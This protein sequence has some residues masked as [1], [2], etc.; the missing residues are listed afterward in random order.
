MR[1]R[2]GCVTC[3]ARPNDPGIGRTVLLSTPGHEM[4]NP[5]QRLTPLTGGESVEV[6]ATR[7]ASSSSTRRQLGA[8]AFACTWLAGASTRLATPLAA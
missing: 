8:V 2:A 6:V 4:F 3:V 5:L 1:L 7:S